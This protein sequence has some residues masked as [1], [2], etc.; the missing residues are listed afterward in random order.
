MSRNDTRKP[1]LDQVLGSIREDEPTRAE[2]DAAADRVRVALGF[3]ASEASASPIH[4]ESCAGFQALMADHLAGRLPR[5]T[6]LLIEDHSRECIPC[7]R[8]L[9]AAQSPAAAT[10]VTTGPTVRRTAWLAAASIAAASLLAGYTAWRVLPGL[11]G[12]PEMKVARVEGD[13]FRVAGNELVPLRAGMTI[14]A[15]QV[16]RTAKDSGALLQLPD[17][18]SIE[19]RDR[20]EF[21]V[22][23]RRGGSTVDLA[24]GSIIIEA[25]PQGANRLRV[26]TD[27]CT[28][29]VKGTI[30]AVNRGTKGSRVSVVEGS[31]EMD[32][33]GSERLLR[34]GDQGTTSASVD[35]VAVADEIAWSRNSA[36]YGKLLQELASLRQDLDARV[37]N[38]KLRY[39]SKLLDF[40]PQE[41]VIYAAIPNL[42][43]A[44]LEARQ[45]FMEHVAE[46]EALQEWWNENMNSPKQR[47][48]MDQ[49]F[50][51]ITEV[52]ALL[53]DEIVVSFAMGNNGKVRGPMVTAEVSDLWALR[54]AFIKQK[55]DFDVDTD[56]RVRGK[57]VTIEPKR[58]WDDPVQLSGFDFQGN[59]FRER[60]AASYKD[61]VSWLFG[62]NL[63]TLMKG[64]VYEASTKGEDGERLTST[65]E[66]MGILDA[67]YL[68]AERDESDQ[69]ATMRAEV[70]FDGQRRG[71]AAWLSDP[72]PMGALEFVSPDASFAAA[73]VVK[74]PEMLI[75]EAV[76][77]MTGKSNQ[78][79]LLSLEEFRA[80]SG[81]DPV[82]DIAGALGGDVA[83][84]VDGPFLPV[85]AW[86]LVI[87]VYDAP[88]LQSSFEKLSRWVNGK[89]EAEGKTGRLTFG[90]EE[91]GNRTDWILRFTGSG[92]DEANMLRYTIVDGYLVAAPTRGLLD[93]AIEQRGNGYSITRAT[94]FTQLLP[95]DGDVNVSALVWQNLGPALGPIAGRL[96]GLLA[97]QE[98]QEMKAFAQGAKP[99]L[100]TFSATHDRIV[101][102]SQGDAG[103][104]SM[105]GS[106][107]SMNQ[108]GMMSELLHE[109]A[110]KHHE[111]SER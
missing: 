104:G 22:A 1:S 32:S 105:L 30:F 35:S 51:N 4:I 67:R 45:V 58:A 47:A 55:S 5:A 44:I 89:L 109:A 59:P 86:K 27:D 79:F 25:A 66:K 26:A 75:T 88:R 61:G 49:A 6:S 10:T 36:R 37:P 73:G 7:R 41:T 2:I 94:A 100:V 107:V 101:L 64:A 93:R 97:D 106:L 63:A 34:S 82:H 38:P 46:S 48:E 8:A 13:L 57:V 91:A 68:I 90:S 102:N 12:G 98:L 42:T 96:T 11:G 21:S 18:S 103:F 60:L 95:R 56:V 62:A 19:M 9:M 23:G 71:L 16:V 81:V 24:G 40:M 84:A 17:G 50:A 14:P 31:V 85:P 20:T 53:G 28:V 33:G 110:E 72:A 78:N 83:I 65:W 29:S 70:T 52:G 108:I 80:E 3:D 77:W 43:D 39:G 69:T 87:E 99:S 74:R 76:G 92:N 15:S 111:G 54:R